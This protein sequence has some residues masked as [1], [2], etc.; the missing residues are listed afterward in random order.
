MTAVTFLCALC[1]YHYLQDISFSLDASGFCLL[2]GSSQLIY[3]TVSEVVGV[4]SLT[5]LRRG[6]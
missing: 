3:V 4:L 2:D 6:K 1:V 5:P